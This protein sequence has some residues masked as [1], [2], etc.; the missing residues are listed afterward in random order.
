M[1]RRAMVGMRIAGAVALAFLLTHEGALSSAIGES[2]AESSQTKANT[3]APNAPPCE[4]T[5]VGK[6]ELKA[7]K[8]EMA[9]DVSVTKCPNKL[10][11][12][13]GKLT[14]TLSYFDQQNKKVTTPNYESQWKDG[15]VP[16]FRHIATEHTPVNFKQLIEVLDE[17][18]FECAC[19]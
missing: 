5:A 6:G 15:K 2:K 1:A 10:N 18:V 9:F 16:K 17:K 8:L 14:Y 3:P 19:H 4:G 11:S 7:D 13:T 12:T